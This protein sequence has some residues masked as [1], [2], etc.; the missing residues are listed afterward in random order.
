MNQMNVSQQQKKPASL[1]RTVL[2]FN[3]KKR[4]LENPIL[5][6]II[7]RP[8]LMRATAKR[9]AVIVQRTAPLLTINGDRIH[10]GSLSNLAISDSFNNRFGSRTPP[11]GSRRMPDHMT[12]RH[13][14]FFL[15]SDPSA[16]NFSP[17]KFPTNFDPKVQTREGTF[18]DSKEGGP[19]TTQLDPL[20]YLRLSSTIVNS[21]KS[22]SKEKLKSMRLF[23]PIFAFFKMLGDVRRRPKKSAYNILT[24]RLAQSLQGWRAF[25]ALLYPLAIDRPLGAPDNNVGIILPKLRTFEN[26]LHQGEEERTL[27]CGPTEET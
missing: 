1:L 6:C 22:D 14:D 8:T 10:E 26:I 18:F 3:I 19:M 13:I 16:E 15:H 24:D 11:H 2:T 9:E 12:L 27:N 7:L 25:H 20:Q 5:P 4:Q 21:E 17:N 23:R